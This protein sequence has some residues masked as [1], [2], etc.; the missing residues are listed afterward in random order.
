MAPSEI[1]SRHVPAPRATRLRCPT[2]ERNE[3]DGAGRCSAGNSARPDAALALIAAGVGLM[4]AQSAWFID[5]DQF[6]RSYL[7]AYLYWT[8]MGIGSL[9]AAAVA[10]MWSA[11]DGEL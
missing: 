4:C 6:F 11:A 7:W 2:Y 1:R 10:I 8:G 3:I 5:R 9:G